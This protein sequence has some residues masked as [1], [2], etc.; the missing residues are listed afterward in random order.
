MKWLNKGHEFDGVY[1]RMSQKRTFYL[2]GAGDYGHQF[3][4]AF[5]NEINI[6]AYIDNDETKQGTR[7]NGLSCLALGQIPM[8]SDTGIIVTMSQI[9]RS[10]PVAQLEDLGFVKNKDYFIIE[11]FISIYHVYKYGKVYFSSVSFLPSTVCNLKCRHCLNFNP[12]AKHF[13][14]REWDDLIRDVDLFFSCVDHIMLFHVSGGEPML[15]KR[16]ADLIEYIDTRYG[17]RI[18]TLRT[19]TNGTVIPADKILEKL[20]RCRLEVTVDDYRDAVP[21]YREN[22]DVLLKKLQEYNIKYYVQKVSSW[23]DLAPE[24]TDYSNLTEEELISHR[25]ACSQSW[26]ELRDGRLFS[27]NYAAYAEVAGISQGDLN[28]S[29]DLREY[30][31]DK[32]KELVEFRLGFTNK[33]YSSFCKKCRGFTIYNRDEVQPAGQCKR[34]KFYE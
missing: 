10:E 27:C 28:D 18:G 13:Y 25:D 24:K 14:V 3:L 9:A 26:Q 11:E 19:V 15:Y 22:F 21:Q 31:P 5:K 2:F 23:V 20:S 16:V 33:G 7:I 8:K 1:S 29:Y 17:E 34:D 32:A 6:A 4:K 30:T 12:F